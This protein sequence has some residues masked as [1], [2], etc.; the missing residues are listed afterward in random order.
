MNFKDYLNN[1]IDENALLNEV[2]FSEKSFEKVSLLYGKIMGKHMGG[3]FKSFGIEDFKRKT[4][5]GKGIRM[6]NSKGYQIRLN[7]DAKKAKKASYDLTSID[8]WDKDNLDFQKPTRTVMFGA[9]L[10]TIQVLDKIVSALKTGNINEAEEIIEEAN[11]ILEKAKTLQQKK[12]WLASKGLR[13]SKAYRKSDIRQEAE[14]AGLLEELEVFLGQT[15]TN[16]F[17]DGLEKVEKKFNQIVYADPDTIFDE[18]EDLVQMI[19][20]GFSK[21]LVITGMGGI[22]KTYHVTEGPR[23]LLKTLGQA[24]GK[25]ELITAPSASMFSF[26]KDCY[27]MRDKIIV[28]DECD[29]L[30]LDK[31]I[32]TSLKGM[33][34]TS[35]DNYLSYSK[36]T[37][38]MVGKTLDQIKDACDEV[39]ME[40]ADGKTIGPGKGEVKLPSKFQFTGS[41]V[42]ISNM[43]IEKFRKVDSGG[44][45]MSRSLFLDIYLEA[46]DVVKR[47]KTIGYAMASSSNFTTDDIDEIVDAL[48]DAGQDD[49]P[50]IK[51]GIAYATA[52]T[53][54]AMKG[55]S[56][57]AMVMAIKM[58]VDMKLPNWK[59]LAAKYA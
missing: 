5:P 57:R 28:W 21:S 18:L 27:L 55:I 13:K 25:W 30:F 22:G 54:R 59:D 1:R 15:E 4:G 45:L 38:S 26:Y 6:M 2:K 50:L 35:G 11:L 9:D 12:E 47:I 53:A 58:K 19:A 31:E 42:F 56:V 17:S 24:G 48:Y 10:N 7:W 3:Q 40:L 20:S 8:Y 41:M 52:G 16:S 44:A 33:L 36:G 23:S 46:T 14:S 34:D 29:E 49:T 39:D 37:E 32:M 51:N 43:K